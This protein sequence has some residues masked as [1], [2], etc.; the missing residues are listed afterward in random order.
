MFINR[1]FVNRLRNGTFTIWP[2][3]LTGSIAPGATGA[4]AIAASGWA[5]ISA[6]AAIP[7]SQA[8][9][10]QNGTA[11]SLQLTGASGV[12]DAAIAQRIEG[13]D[14][15]QLAGQQATFQMAIF[16]NTGSPITPILVTATAGAPDNWSISTPDFSAPLQTCANG[17]W[18]TVAFTFP[19]SANAIDGY[20]IRVDFGK[21][22][23][24]SSSNS[25][26]VTAADLRATPGVSTCLNAYPPLPELP[27][28][29]AEAVRCERYYETSYDNGLPPGSN[30]RG[31]IVQG[32]GMG[33]GAGGPFHY[34]FTFN[35]R[36][37]KH[38]VPVIAYFD[39]AGNPNKL[40]GNTSGTWTDNVTPTG[41]ALNPSTK[42]IF[43]D[44]YY[45]GAF[46]TAVQY[47]AYADFW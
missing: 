47:T 28:V 1:G 33:Y 45:V 26:R 27:T 43:S 37:E 21:G 11:E 4:A 22:A 20:E 5:V 8:A 25:V 36:T 30:T 38:A 24:T 35:F 16:N 29:A 41:G 7:W 17:A 10:G 18:T 46:P 14:A 13:V 2:N 3:G 42:A 31:G 12:T 39:G 6:G 15:A 23:L 32:P 9:A 34:S 19:V 44:L 40:S